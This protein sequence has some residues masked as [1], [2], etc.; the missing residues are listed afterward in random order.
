MFNFPYTN[1]HDLNLD[2]IL[3]KIKELF[4]TAVFTV[5]NT[6]PDDNGN[7]NLSGVSGVTSVCGIGADGSGNVALSAAN[8]GAVGEINSKQP[9]AQG[10][11][12]LNT[13]VTTTLIPNTDFVAAINIANDY[14]RAC[15]RAG[16][17]AFVSRFTVENPISGG[18]PIISGFPPP[19]GGY[20]VFLIAIETTTS[21]IVKIYIDSY[22]DLAAGGT[23]TP[24]QYQ[25]SA[26]YLIGA[27]GT[28]NII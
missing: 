14:T 13:E 11:I 27:P 1:F 5:N 6:P 26:S 20:P 12:S 8:I 25:T 19:A 3:G 24:G 23:I 17:I 16:I 4:N 18:D 10:Q 2:W 7:V 22:G 28:L 21:D 15:E 9:N